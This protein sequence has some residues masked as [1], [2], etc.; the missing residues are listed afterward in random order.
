[1]RRIIA[2]FLFV[3]PCI[4]MAVYYLVGGHVP[5][6][7]DHMPVVLA[8]GFL[9]LDKVWSGVKSVVGT[10][11][12]TATN[13]LEQIPVVGPPIVA[14]MQSAEAVVSGGGVTVTQGGTTTSWGTSAQ[15]PGVLA[16]FTAMTVAGV[17]LYLILAG[18]L[19][20]Y[21]LFAKKGKR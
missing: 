14:G 8:A 9:G 1:M 17:P 21:L 10:V 16:G 19:L 15:K 13:I 7:A 11:Y 6:S 5:T 3:I 12:H 4:Y 20:A 18:G 2:F